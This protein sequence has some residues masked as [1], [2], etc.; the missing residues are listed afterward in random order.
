MI[1][2]NAATLGVYTLY[3][4]S[5]NTLD[6]AALNSNK[7]TL[8]TD[9][10]TIEVTLYVRDFPLETPVTITLGDT[11]TI[12]VP[13]VYSQIGITPALDI[14]L[15]QPSDG[16]QLSFVSFNEDETDHTKVIIETSGAGS[17]GVYPMYLYSFSTFNSLEVLREDTIFVEITNYIRDNPLV[18]AVTVKKD[19]LLVVIV[20]NVYSS[21]T[22]TPIQDINVR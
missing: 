18:E 13:H 9:I 10:I 19:D 7:P 4:E 5:F 22:I 2:S 8:R 1:D 14:N 21:I 11:L 15:M 17:H 12:Q 20:P 3:L 16:T 6:P